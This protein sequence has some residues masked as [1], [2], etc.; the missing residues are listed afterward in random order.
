MDEDST[1]ATS[2]G[3]LITIGRSFIVE[4]LLRAIKVVTTLRK[5][6]RLLAVIATH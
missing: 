4:K 5:C 1:D 2:D 3:N 6:A